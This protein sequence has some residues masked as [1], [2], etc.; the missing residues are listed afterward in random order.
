VTQLYLVR[1]GEAH[2]E[3]DDSQRTLTKGGRAGVEAIARWAARAGVRPD[4]ICH[5]GKTRAR[6]TAE[7]LQR[8][9]RV[10]DVVAVNGIAP[11]DEPEAFA[12][13]IGGNDMVVGHLPFLSRLTSF[14]LIGDADRTLIDFAPGAMIC[15]TKA[16]N[17]W[18]LAFAITPQM[19]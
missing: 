13:I 5:S 17:E 3:G 9:L 2:A 14:L 6:E 15:L 4:R 11:T 12:Q 16:D 1:H 7:I 18:R 19:A 8:R 10:S